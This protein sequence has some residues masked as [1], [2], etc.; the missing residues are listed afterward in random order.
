MEF[1]SLSCIALRTIANI[2]GTYLFENIFGIKNL[3]CPAR[4]PV[5]WL[6][7][8]ESLKPRGRAVVSLEIAKGSS[9]EAS[10]IGRWKPEIHLSWS[11][12]YESNWKCLNTVPLG[13]L[14][15][16]LVGAA[17]GTGTARMDFIEENI[18]DVHLCR[19]EDEFTRYER[20]SLI[21]I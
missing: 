7:D 8:S 15:M 6:L 17:G 2:A 4:V 18:V 1:F 11:C 14:N 19:K 3:I 9:D 10:K 12:A 21:H 16:H 5:E 13:D 20:L